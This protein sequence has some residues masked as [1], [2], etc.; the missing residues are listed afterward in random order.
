[1]TEV[2]GVSHFSGAVRNNDRQWS[3]NPIRGASVVSGLFFDGFKVLFHNL[4]RTESKVFAPPSLDFLVTDQEF[5]LQ[6]EGCYDG[7]DAGSWKKIR[8]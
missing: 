7:H 4:I 5:C 8:R 3:E 1:M 6:L 2:T